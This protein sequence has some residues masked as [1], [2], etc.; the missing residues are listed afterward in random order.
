LKA[1]QRLNAQN[2]P[3]LWL[4]LCNYFDGILFPKFCAS[5]HTPLIQLCKEDDLVKIKKKNEGG[6]LGRLFNEKFLCDKC[7]NAIKLITSPLCS[8]CGNPF[9]TQTG[10]DHICGHCLKK[11][12]QFEWARS[13]FSYESTIQAL[14]K[15]IKYN[16]SGYGLKSLASLSKPLL[17][18]RLDKLQNIDLICP[19]PIHSSRL[20]KRGFNQAA[21]L[22]YEIFNNHKDKIVPDLLIKYKATPPQVGLSR[23]ERYLNVSNSFRVSKKIDNKSVLI[24]DDVLTTGATASE[25]AKALK[26]QGAKDVFV[27]T[28]ARSWIAD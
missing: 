12:P 16:A 28:I 7:Y 6:Q 26:K 14:I 13:L 21:M 9:K 5:C 24:F 4:I 11:P 23:K 22:A 3:K 8:I 17:A 1:L 27:L 10:P 19:V 25:C 15:E 18:T 20:R 2:L